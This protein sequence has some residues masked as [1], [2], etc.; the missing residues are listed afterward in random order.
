MGGLAPAF[1]V[2]PLDSH[3]LACRVL[4]HLDCGPDAFDGAADG[5]ALPVLAWQETADDLFTPD[6]VQTRLDGRGRLTGTK[7]HVVGHDVAGRLLVTARAETG[8]VLARVRADAPG[9]DAVTRWRADGTPLADLRLNDV[10]AQVLCA[11]PAR[12]QDAIDRARDE[13][14]VL[15]AVELMAQIDTMMTLLLDHLRSREQFGRP[16]GAFQALQHRAADLY[17]RQLLSRAVLD[18]AVSRLTA[19]LDDATARLHLVNRVRA[20]LNATARHVAR[21]AIQMFGAMGITDECDLGLHVK[22][23]LALT[24]WLGSEQ[25]HRSRF[26]QTM[27]RKTDTEPTEEFAQ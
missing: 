1:M 26:A 22:R 2:A 12:V 15:V 21:D 4:V 20:R 7:R 5:T 23:V 13:T 11:D 16:I 25:Q 3:F 9:V 17:V 14:C 19:G 8:L 18:P 24:P 27:D 6:R 10:P